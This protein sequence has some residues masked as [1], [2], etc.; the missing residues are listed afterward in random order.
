LC[1][2]YRI[3]LQAI[4]VGM[5]EFKLGEKVRITRGPYASFVGTVERVSVT[6]LALVVVVEVFGRRVPLV[7][8]S[9]A[10]EKLPPEDHPT[11]P[12]MNLN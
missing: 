7:V 10:V 12:S 6:K 2:Y 9:R 1:K 5:Q 8:S 4:A 11:Q 3:G